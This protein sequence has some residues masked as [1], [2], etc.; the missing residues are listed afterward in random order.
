MRCSSSQSQIATRAQRNIAKSFVCSRGNEQKKREEKSA[1]EQQCCDHG[2]LCALLQFRLS[3][4]AHGVV[5]VFADIW[6]L[7][8]IMA[9][10]QRA[11][12]FLAN[13]EKLQ[14]ETSCNHIITRFRELQR[15]VCVHLK[16][17]ILS[18]WVSSLW[19][20]Q[21][22]NVCVVSTYTRK[23]KS[24][25]IRYLAAM[26]CVTK[27]VESL[28]DSPNSILLS[29]C[30]WPSSSRSVLRMKMRRKKMQRI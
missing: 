16:Q 11:N 15:L 6:R 4:A 27:V 13:A 3:T 19:L 24:L 21:R 20:W 23:S 1:L 14:L 10:V 5:K 28:D 29:C 26:C 18:R 22:S 2:K 12:A 17:F 25:A 30:A 7:T 8:S 9:A